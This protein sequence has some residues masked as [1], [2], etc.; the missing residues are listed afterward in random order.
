[1]A[2]KSKRVQLAPQP[3]LKNTFIRWSI[4]ILAIKAIIMM[5]ISGGYLNETWGRNIIIKGIWLG[6]DGENYI[7]G[8]FNLVKDGLF[9]TDPSLSYFPA[10]YPLIILLLSIF[11]KSWLFIT[12]SIF[13]SI[14]F[15]YAA[16]FFALQLSKTR[17]KKFSFLVFIFIILNPTLSLFSLLLGYEILTASGYLFVSG[18][19]IKDLIEKNDKKFTVYLIISSF[20][21]GLMTFVQ[22]RL[23]ISGLLINLLWLLIRKGMKAGSLIMIISN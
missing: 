17:L 20:I 13:Q 15:S 10:G 8:Y 6:S 12:I 14:L 19:I 7:S 1:M 5:N 3:N 2:S 21:F 11:G 16:Y 9:S 22:P 23:I 18:L 4:A